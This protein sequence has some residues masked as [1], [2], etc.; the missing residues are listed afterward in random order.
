MGF[1]TEF[2]IF[3]ADL[4]ECADGLPGNVV[5]V[6][7]PIHWIW[8]K[9]RFW[10]LANCWVRLREGNVSR[11][12]GLQ[13]RNPF[14]YCLIH[15]LWWLILGSN[16]IRFES[17]FGFL[18]SVNLTLILVRLQYSFCFL[19]NQ[20]S[21][22]IYYGSNWYTQEQKEKNQRFRKQTHLWIF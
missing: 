12:K 20:M 7:I 19:T 4:L 21:S 15:S 22:I 8:D 6:Q 11:M 18:L 9:P 17:V 14:T 2:V 5:K 1:D 10:F 13:I 16:A 3:R